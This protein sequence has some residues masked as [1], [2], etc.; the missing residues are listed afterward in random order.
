MKGDHGYAAEA[1]VPVK[2]PQ[3]QMEE[4]RGEAARELAISGRRQLGHSKGLSRNRM[5]A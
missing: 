1:C 3:V 5:S 4:Q 2:M